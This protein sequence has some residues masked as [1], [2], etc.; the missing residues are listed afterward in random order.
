MSERAI[1]EIYSADAMRLLKVG[2]T[3]VLSL[4]L[5]LPSVATGQE[6]TAVQQNATQPAQSEL[7]ALLKR[8]ADIV[9]KLEIKDEAKAKRV[10]Q[11]VSDQHRALYEILSVRAAKLKALEDAAGEGKPSGEAVTAV[12]VE[13][14]EK[15]VPLHK[16]FLVRLSTELTP[17]QVVQV[18]DGMTD[19][20]LPITY[21]NFC[22]MVPN[23][24]AEQK[25]HIMSLLVEARENAMDTI[26]DEQRHQWFAKYKGIINNYIVA[27]GYDFKRLS[28]E[29][30]QRTGNTKGP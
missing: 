15:L 28:R 10:L 30:A 2:L 6:K 24:T 14:K 7:A 23:M 25:A 27:Q 8:A 26:T 29:W 3:T 9:S 13:A 19:G 16:Q 17:E 20:V 5:M 1:N 21:R 11:I 12:Y 18:K 22:D 4:A